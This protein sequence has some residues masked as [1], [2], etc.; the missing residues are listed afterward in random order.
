MG[1]G[2][3][4]GHLRPDWAMAGDED[5]VPDPQQLNLWLEVDGR[6]YQDGSTRTMIFGVRFLISYISRFMSLHPGDITSTG[7]PAGVGLGQKPPVYLR[8]GNRIR[9]GIDG[10]G[11]QTH[12][13]ET[14]TNDATKKGQ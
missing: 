6:R 3:E 1:K 14:E 8:E 11:E 2:Q 5:D 7:T 9:L 10:L 12:L 4:R 13:V